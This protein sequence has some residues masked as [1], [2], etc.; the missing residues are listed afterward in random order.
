MK[1]ELLAYG[2]CGNSAAAEKR[3]H[4]EL[5]KYRKGTYE[6]FEMNFSEAVTALHGVADEVVVVRKP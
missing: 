1:L 2:P 6:L 3:I 4:R 5:E